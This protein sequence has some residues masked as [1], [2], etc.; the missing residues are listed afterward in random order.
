[1]ALAMLKARA[2]PPDLPAFAPLPVQRIAMLDPRQTMSVHVSG[3]LDGGQIPLVCISGFHRNMSDFT[4][5]LGIFRRSAGPSS[6]IILIDLPGRGRSSDRRHFSEYT[7]PADARDLATALTALAIERALFLGQGH[8]GQVVMALAGARPT[9]VAGAILIDAGPVAAP[10]GLVRLRS[11][12]RDLEGLR[13][14]AGLRSMFRRMLGAD[15]PGQPD[16]VLDRLAGRTH[17]L[18]KRRKVRALFDPALLKFLDQFEFDDVFEAQWPLF[19]G[20]DHA[21]LML[22]RTQLTDLLHRDVFDEMLRRRPDAEG[23]VVEQ[24]ATPA[25]LS[26]APDVANIL[27]FYSRI[28]TA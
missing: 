17:Y 24:Q 9:L 16:P 7:S 8:G 27:E 23:F 5:F 20:L 11:N 22:M 2:V 18:D 28:A 26:H 3:R 25:L 4:E 19:H 1:M 15:Y 13:S 14:E 12:L 10:R 6:P 21:P